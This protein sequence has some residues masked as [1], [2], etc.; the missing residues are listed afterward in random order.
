MKIDEDRDKDRDNDL[1]PANTVCIPARVID[2]KKRVEPGNC[3][4]H[5]QPPGS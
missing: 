1:L 3:E 4:H 2:L 5:S